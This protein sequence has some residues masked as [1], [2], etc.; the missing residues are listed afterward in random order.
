[1]FDIFYE[2]VSY[3]LGTFDIT[4]IDQ[5]TKIFHEKYGDIV[6]VS[7]ILGRPDMVILYDPDEI[8][9]VFRREETMPY[10]PSMPSLNYYK[11]IYRKNFFGDGGGVI[12]VYVTY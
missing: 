2:F 10:R 1:M 7:G 3:I 6:R 5:A 8:E 4:R 9:K 12:A 11:H